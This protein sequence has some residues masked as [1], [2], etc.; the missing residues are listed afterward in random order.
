VKKLISM[1]AV[2]LFSAGFFGGCYT[3]SGDSPIRGQVR[4]SPPIVFGSYN[5]KVVI[6][7]STPHAFELYASGPVTFTNSA[8]YV[9]QPSPAGTIEMNSGD[10]VQA[11]YRLGILGFS[12]TRA[13]Q[14]TVLVAQMRVN[15]DV[16]TA[17]E[18][19]NYDSQRIRTEYWKLETRDFK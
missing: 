8:G 7:N 5:L 19:Y 4:N 10:I 13:R 12:N 3:I 11:W 16:K 9:I 18:E 17:D 14:N 1:L 2:L 6:N 15:G